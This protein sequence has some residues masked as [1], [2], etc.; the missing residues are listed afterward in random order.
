MYKKNLKSA[1]YSD[2]NILLIVFLNKAAIS[3]LIFFLSFK[4]KKIMSSLIS[5]L[6]TLY[7]F[8]LY[9]DLN[10][11]CNLIIINLFIFF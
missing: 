2:L 8:F 6:K 11:Q 7:L 3:L 5:A 10:L 1:I 9:L 4:F